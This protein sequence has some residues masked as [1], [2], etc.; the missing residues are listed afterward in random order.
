MTVLRWQPAMKLGIP[1]IDADHKRLVGL[2]NT[3]HYAMIAGDDR[4]GLGNVLK[5]L[6]DYTRTHFA[7]EEALMERS[8]Y[9]ELEAH[10]AI[11][12]RIAAAMEEHR[13]TFLDEPD[14]FDMEE[15]YDF[16]SGWLL[17]HVLG[18]DMKLKPY[19]QRLAAHVAA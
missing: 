11:H 3:L 5:E 12:R 18:E 16:V 2:L 1:G 6:V 13:A 8:G 10:Q 15:F 14:A 17:H 9:P 4:S 19:F 7:R